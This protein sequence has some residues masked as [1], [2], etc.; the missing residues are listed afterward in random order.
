M[1]TQP[2]KIVAAIALLAAGVAAG[3]ALATWRAPSHGA[4]DQAAA[5]ASAERQVLYWYDPMRPDQKFDKP[6]KSPFMDMQLVPKYADEAGGAA[7]AGGVSVSPQ[8]V[9]AL[10]LRVA[11]AEKRSL[12]MVVDAVGTVQLN[13]RDVSIVQARANGF[14]ERVYARAPGDVIAAGAPLAD[15][16]HPEWL[17]AQQEYLAVRATGDA[18]LTAAARQRLTL[19]GMPSSLVERVERSGRP[20]ATTTITTPGG[21]LIAELMVRQGMTVTAGMT[22]ARINGLSTVWV[23]AALPEAQ[24]GS[25]SVGQPATVRLAADT[26][27]P[28]RGK[29]SAILP[30]ANAETRTLRVR[31]ELPNPGLRLRAGMFAQVQLQ[32]SAQGEAVT[33]PTEAV[34]RTGRRALLY[35]V[36]EPGRYRPVEVELGPEVSERIVVRRGI[37]AGQ[38]VVA[39]GQFLIDSEASLRGIVAQAGSAAATPPAALAAP[40]GQAATPQ[41][42]P[43][44]AATARQY[45]TRG[46]VVEID[47]DTITLE[48]EAVPAL[49][50]PPMTM[51]FKLEKPELARGLKPK[52]PVRFT[53]RSDDGDSVVTAIERQAAP[54]HAGHGTGGRP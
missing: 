29:V 7:A 46:V 14:V 26:G 16:L 18:A 32:G 38:Q 48:H 3:W 22:L 25:V 9:Q 49:K 41:A 6:G 43:G 11:T 37:E 51:P 1:N 5:A 42:S 27:E 50:W 35:V 15:V 45:D 10:G 24:A 31:V 36:D 47:G 13:E 28:L 8:A 23:E 30:E 33:V 2:K 12:G 17:A 21:G 53:F 40:P 54:G 44:A 4:A 19:L 20:V 52:D 34:I 39:S